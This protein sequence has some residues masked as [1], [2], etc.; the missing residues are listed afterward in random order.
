MKTILLIIVGLMTFCC[1]TSSKENTS[2]A[3]TLTSEDVWNRYGQL[4]APEY[5]YNDFDTLFSNSLKSELKR[6]GNKAVFFYIAFDIR[7]SIMTEVNF[8]PMDSKLDTNIG[9]DIINTLKG[10]R[11]IYEFIEDYEYGSYSFAV[12]R[13]RF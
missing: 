1:S 3:S 10:H 12:D 6:S 4:P 13:T 11:P 5:V 2:K 7:D 8:S 9:N